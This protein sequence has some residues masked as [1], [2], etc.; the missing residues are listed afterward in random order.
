MTKQGV[1]YLGTHKS[2]WGPPLSKAW[3]TASLGMGVTTAMFFFTYI[4]HTAILSITSGPLLGPISAAFMI[5]TESST[6]TNYLARRYIIGDALLDVFDGT[7]VACGEEKLV[8]EGRQV[9]RGRNS[10]GKDPMA[11]LGAIVKRP[12]ES[13]RE[14]NPQAVV[15]S[16]L[17][18]PLNFVPVVGTVLYVFVQGKKVGPL[19]HERYFQLKKWDTERASKGEKRKAWVEKKR[20]AYTG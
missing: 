3:P 4:P 17:L 8:A 2:L 9:E 12:L 1:F 14:L 10:K 5:L 7:L 19:L 11:R 16:L 18:L 15:K 20:A 6:I 13:A